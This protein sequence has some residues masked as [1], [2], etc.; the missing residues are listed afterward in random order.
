[1]ATAK[2]KVEQAEAPFH[3][4]VKHQFEFNERGSKITDPDEIQRVIDDG[5]AHHCMKVAGTGIVS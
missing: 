4:V 5:Y 3:F 1:M 2:K